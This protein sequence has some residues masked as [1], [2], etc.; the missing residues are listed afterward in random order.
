LI[1]YIEYSNPENNVVKSNIVS[2]FDLLYK[3]YSNRLIPLKR[4]MNSNYRFK[5]Q[6]IIRVLLD[7]VFN[8]EQYDLCFY[9]EEMLLRNLIR[10]ISKLN[11]EELQY[12]NNR[13]SLDFVIYRKIGKSCVLAIEVDGFEYHENNPKQLNRD[14]LKN[15]ILEKYKIP[16]LRLPTNHS[17]EEEKLKKKLDEL[18]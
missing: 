1:R 2:V 15:S 13:A 14:R 12:V 4:R 3:N 8:E 17:G 16:L 7:K 6:E 11:K 10:D 9:A 18:L 5:S